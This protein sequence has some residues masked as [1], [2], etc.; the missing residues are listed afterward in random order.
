MT[1]H[2]EMSPPDPR[3]ED[4]GLH[5]QIAEAFIN[6]MVEG[7]GFVKVVFDPNGKPID[8]TI[9]TVNPA[10]ERHT[11]IKA[12]NFVQKRLSEVDPGN[13]SVWLEG[14]EEVARRHGSVS[15]ERYSKNT[16][17]WF[18]VEIVPMPAKNIYAFIL[19]DITE[20]K[21]ERW[22]K[23]ENDRRNRYL[24][25]LNDSL[26]SIEEPEQILIKAAEFL[27]DHLDAGRVQYF[28][29]ER[30]VE[31]SDVFGSVTASCGRH[32][33]PMNGP[34]CLTD[35]G[36]GSVDLLRGGTMVVRD[37]AADSRF[38]AAE[39]ERCKAIDVSAQIIVP[40]IRQRGFVAALIVHQNGPRD[41]TPYEVGIARETAERTWDALERVRA[42]N[43]LK[44]TREVL[45]KLVDERTK[46]LAKSELKYRT[47]A[48]TANDGFWWTDADGR[49]TEIS[50]GLANLLGYQVDELLGRYWT[51]LIDMGWAVVALKIWGEREPGKV[52]QFDLKIRRK[53]GF[54]IW[55]Q[56]RFM[57]VT[58]EHDRCI[59]TL[60]ALT[61]IDERKRVEE[62]LRRSNEE[63]KQF[64][65]VA[66]HD[67]REPLRMVTSYLELLERKY[68]GKVLD[69]KAKVYMHFAIDGAQR[70]QR[71]IDDLL[72]YSRVDKLGK[73][74]SPVEMDKV[75]ATALKDLERSIDDS[76]ATI[77][78]DPLPTI[79]ADGDQMVLLLENLISNALKFRG[80]EAP[81]ISIS[82]LQVADEWTFSV[83]DNG[84]GIDPSQMDRL[85]Q[86]FVRLHSKEEYEGTGIGLAI[87]KKIVER[88]GG[89]IWVESEPGAGSTFHFT[90]PARRYHGRTV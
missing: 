83:K 49:I 41:W 51:D 17:R 75:L 15:I 10:F 13:E 62:E 58:D 57:P 59:G 30:S 45:E 70:M 23:E 61:S 4:A 34:F 63:L 76:G 37:V 36:I 86:M 67:L 73:P 66:S 52:S 24:H 69:E 56:M 19:H 72:A 8:S 82:A 11:G 18:N 33:P 68:D 55:M 29:A 88:H 16:D 35:L 87:C 21:K 40:L 54:S 20:E 50:E 44:R 39:I 1:S 47:L 7:V 46:K 85:F 48:E 9:L 77:V 32:L 5:L 27:A 28:V 89:R 42:Q 65:Y 31:P 43:A 6:N 60:N 81:R 71:M 79:I 84:I 80:D 2:E 22:T 26:R 3:M 38:G 64:A 74:F 12:E 78:N 14:Y 25:D 90:I 53:D